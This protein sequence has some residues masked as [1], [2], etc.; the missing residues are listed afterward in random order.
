MVSS[1]IL[2]I[3]LLICFICLHDAIQV[4]IIPEFVWQ[5]HH[6]RV[7]ECDI[8]CE[9]SEEPENPDAE[10]YAAINNEDVKKFVDSKSEHP[11]KIIASEEGEHY[12]HLLKLEYL[13]QHFQATSLINRHSDIPLVLMPDMDIVKAMKVSKRAQPKASFVAVNCDP[14]NNRNDYVKA[15]AEVI[16]VDAPSNCFNNMK[17][18][19]CE[20]RPCTKVEILRN[21]KFNLA[22]ENGDS[23]GYV[24]EKIYDAF[25][26]GVLPVYMGTRDVAEAVPKGSYIYVSDFKTPQDVAN[27]LKKV[28]RNETLY[29]SYF[30]WKYKHDDTEFEKR[31]RALWEDDYF[32]RV[33][34]Y[35]DAIKRGVGWDR[36]YQRAVDRILPS[37]A[38]N[39]KS[40]HPDNVP[41]D[42]ILNYSSYSFFLLV[43]D[44]MDHN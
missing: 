38:S 27:Y 11:L 19:F 21:Y 9:F 32:C 31:N 22:F 23:P 26:A 2:V 43:F 18:P 20:G 42:C 25:E 44:L 39:E 33:C 13:K 1:T 29:R 34:Y 8:P 6:A 3:I 37:E 40:D 7:L 36:I 14:K 4:K 16:W 5:G 10:F 12:Y 41:C 35:V 28:I 24:T 17:W 15:I 30:Q